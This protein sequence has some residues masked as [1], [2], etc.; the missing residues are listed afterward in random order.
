VKGD[1]VRRGPEWDFPCRPGR[2]V[3]EVLR[4]QAD[5]EVILQQ[6]LLAWRISKLYTR[7]PQAHH[8]IERMSS[9][10]LFDQIREE[11]KDNVFCTK[12]VHK[13]GHFI[14]FWGT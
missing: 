6:V 12:W 10:R 14:L 1:K 9:G 2:V 7:K 8:R 5:A 4:E 11:A 13:F 3:Q